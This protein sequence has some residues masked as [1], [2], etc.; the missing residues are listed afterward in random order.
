MGGSLCT[1]TWASEDCLIYTL[2]EETQMEGESVAVTSQITIEGIRDAY[3]AEDIRRESVFE[4]TL[5]RE[6]V[7]DASRGCL[8]LRRVTPDES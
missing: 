6:Y 5:R 8:V 1:G 7:Y 2:T 3:T 4:K